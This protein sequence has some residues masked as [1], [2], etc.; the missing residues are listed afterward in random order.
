MTTDRK[1]GYAPKTR[2]LADDIARL[3][4]PCVGCEGCEGLCMAL[5]EAMVLPDLILSRGRGR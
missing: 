4:G 5:I 2:A 1:T 3:Q